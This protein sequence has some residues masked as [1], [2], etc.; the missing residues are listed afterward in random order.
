MGI[1]N[2]CFLMQPVFVQC[3]YAKV[4]PPN[5]DSVNCT[6]TQTAQW[7]NGTEQTDNQNGNQ[8][9]D[10]GTGDVGD[11][12]RKSE[13]P[14][15]PETQ[16]WLSLQEEARE[17]QCSSWWGAERTASK[18]SSFTRLTD[19]RYLPNHNTFHVSSMGDVIDSLI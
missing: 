3:L 15:L 1:Y 12:H 5:T 18:Q 6:N 2:K 11:R 13:G 16:R 8:L 10:P 14:S 7:P 17:R 4:L 9:C 19:S